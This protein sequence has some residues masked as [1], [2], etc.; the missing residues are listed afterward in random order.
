[1]FRTFVVLNYFRTVKAI[2]RSNTL[3]SKNGFGIYLK[4]LSTNYKPV[5][6][7][8]LNFRYFIFVKSFR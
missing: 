5:Q 3:F 2:G 6:K 4:A 1:M 7:C 8:H